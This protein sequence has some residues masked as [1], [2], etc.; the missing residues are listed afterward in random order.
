M[1][2]SNI[3]DDYV[4]EIDNQDRYQTLLKS[5]STHSNKNIVKTLLAAGA[6]INALTI[7]GDT[8]LSKAISNN[9]NQSVKLLLRFGAKQ[10]ISHIVIDCLF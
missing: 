9:Q 3:F 1:V 10:N 8:P 4:A 2:D 6:D 5:E 7:G